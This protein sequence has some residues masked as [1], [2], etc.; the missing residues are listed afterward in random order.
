MPIKLTTSLLAL[1]AAMATPV[2]ADVTAADVWSNQQSLYAA[3]GGTLNG[4]LSADGNVSPV[5]NFILP[6]GFGSLQVKLSEI[7]FAENNDGSVTI[8][9]PSPMNV[10]VAGGIA[11]EG[12][13]A[14]DLTMSSSGYVSVA[15]G[16]AGDVSYETNVNDWEIDITNVTLDGFDGADV[17]VAGSL[18]ID[19]WSNV[20]RVIE[21]DLVTYSTASN[22]GTST[23]EIVFKV[24]NITSTTTQTSQPISATASASLQAGGSDLMNLS[25]AL[26]DGLSF[27]AQSTGGGRTSSTVAVLNG[28]VLNSQETATGPQ[29]AT[30]VFDENGIV[31]DAQAEAFTMTMNDPILF[32]TPLEFAIDAISAAYALP[33]NASDDVQDFRVATTLDGITMGDTIWALL[34]PAGRLPRDPANVSF[35]ITGLGTNG[36]DL[37][38]FAALST[39]AG[40]PPVQVDEVTIENLNIAAV[41]AEISA[42]GA[43]TFDW[44]DFQTLP[45]MPRPEGAIT[46]NLNGANALMDTLA[47]MGFIPAEELL[48]PRM[49]MGMFATPVGDDMLESVVEMNAEGHLLANGQRLQ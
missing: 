35:D 30:L 25:Q 44:T 5:A 13:F 40:P 29:T 49:M 47:D 41:G 11:G 19:A 27:T 10:S 1:S 38:D 48:V 31:L 2:L 46:I 21:G 39:L 15:T 34:D 17:S 43:M 24:D 42:K 9:Y 22:T 3:F 45:G 12:S 4:E 36:L 16:D 8:T 20:A 23:T 6:N 28:D 33:L 14:A 7:T 32:P 37:L 18:A 26:R